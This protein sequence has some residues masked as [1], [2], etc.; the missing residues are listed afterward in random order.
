MPDD[1]H[2]IE[3]GTSKLLIFLQ[4]NGIMAWEWRFAKVEV[5]QGISVSSSVLAWLRVKTQSRET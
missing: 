1:R 2:F 4:P 3:F 5:Q